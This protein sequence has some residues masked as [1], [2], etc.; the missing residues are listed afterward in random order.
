MAGNNAVGVET[1]LLRIAL[2]KSQLNSADG[3]LWSMV[4]PELQNTISSNNT[5]EKFLRPQSAL[6]LN[7]NTTT[8]SGATQKGR[9]DAAVSAVWL[10]GGS[11]RSVHIPGL[12]PTRS[13]SKWSRQFESN[14]IIISS[15]AKL[16]LFRVHCNMRLLH[17]A[18]FQQAKLL[19]QS[20]THANQQIASNKAN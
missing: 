8:S 12:T 7:N 16:T 2:A 10:V 3:M 9:T 11:M 1:E 20:P 14:E 4:L 15:A 5:V 17:C 6:V 19:D 13:C 18:G